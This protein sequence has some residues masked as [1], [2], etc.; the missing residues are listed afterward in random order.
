MR[1]D[2]N[3][4]AMAGSAAVTMYGAPGLE[5]LLI[6]RFLYGLGIGEHSRPAGKGGRRQEPCEPSL[7]LRL[8]V[9]QCMRLPPTLQRR[10]QLGFVAF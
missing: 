6:G 1:S 8:Q 4:I 2:E 3:I 7:C 5:V 10:P 9:S